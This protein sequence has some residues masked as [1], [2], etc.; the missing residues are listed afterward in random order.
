MHDWSKQESSRAKIDEK[1]VY[2]I[3]QQRSASKFV[4]EY[5]KGFG[6]R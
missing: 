3:E 2:W 4:K 6:E 1:D 5:E